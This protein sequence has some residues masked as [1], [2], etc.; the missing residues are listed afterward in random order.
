[1]YIIN[2]NSRVLHLYCFP[3]C[4]SVS[5]EILQGTAAPSLVVGCIA[6]RARG[7]L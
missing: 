7:I 4:I 3:F 1:M 2:K 5:Y 6:V